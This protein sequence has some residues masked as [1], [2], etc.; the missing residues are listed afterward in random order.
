MTLSAVGASLFLSLRDTAH[1][2]DVSD[3]SPLLQLA[4]ARRVDQSVM[5]RIAEPKWDAL[6]KDEQKR[7]ATVVFERE[8]IKGVR[9]MTLVDG[10]QRVRVIATNATGTTLVT[11][12]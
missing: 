1:D 6:P 5:A 10:K 12:Q 8:A 9:A 3:V 11:V 4:D 7:L 2:Y